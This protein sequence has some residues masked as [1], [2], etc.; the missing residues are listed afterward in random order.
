MLVA[1]AVAW[2]QA[3]RSLS[4]QDADRLSAIQRE[5]QDLESSVLGTHEGYLRAGQ[6]V[7]DA[8]QAV[9]SHRAAHESQRDADADYS[10]ARSEHDEA[11]NAFEQ[12][13]A[14]LRA[15][16]REQGEQLASHSRAKAEI[17]RLKP[18][19]VRLTREVER[20]E[21]NLAALEQS[22]DESA[23]R[24]A[25][26]GQ[27][28]AQESNEHSIGDAREKLEQARKELTDANAGLSTAQ[29]AQDA[30]DSASEQLK[31]RVADARTQNTQARKRQV[32]SQTRLSALQREWDSK[33]RSDPRTHELDATVLAARDQL[34]H[35]RRAAL[36]SLSTQARYTELLGER[37]AIERRRGL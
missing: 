22:S 7:R 34:E 19:I 11:N 9:K 1:T 4:P 15:L 20:R 8:E 18:V 27:D 23:E 36:E 2:S 21:R 26:P 31:P 10:A 28:T 17:A 32:E 5:I 13:S 16:L 14:A 12:T 35:V 29:T 3:E 25:R 30:A 37:D 33:L 24:R 6:A